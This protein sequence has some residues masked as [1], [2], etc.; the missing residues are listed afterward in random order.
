MEQILAQAHLQELLRM[1]LQVH[2]VPQVLR[3]QQA[4]QA[5]AEAAERY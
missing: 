3:V 1:V 4:L 5:E 2:L